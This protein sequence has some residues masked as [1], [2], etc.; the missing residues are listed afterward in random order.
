MD[1]VIL[2]YLESKDAT[3]EFEVRYS[4]RI[5]RL[6]YNSIV[7][8][9]SGTGFKIESDQKLLRIS[10]ADCR[11]QIAGLLNIKAYC[12]NDRLVDATFQK[13]VVKA[14]FINAY[15]M[16]AAL[17]TEVVL[18]A[19]EEEQLRDEW[20]VLDKTFRFMHRVTLA[21][22][23]YP[24]FKVDCSVVKSSSRHFKRFSL[25]DVFSRP[26]TCEVEIEALRREDFEVFKRQLNKISTLVLGG[27]QG[28]PFPVNSVEIK[29]VLTEYSKMTK[30]DLSVPLSRRF[31]GPNSVTLQ[32]AN[33]AAVATAS[34]EVAEEDEVV[35]DYNTHNIRRNYV[36]TDKADGLRKLLFVRGGRLY[37][38]TSKMEVEYAGSTVEDMDDT[39]L[40]GEFIEADKDGKPLRLFACFDVYF[41]K[42]VDVR[43]KL[44]QERKAVL[45]DVVA[46][47]LTRAVLK[48]HL[49]VKTFYSG[50]IFAACRDCLNTRY[51]YVT[52]GL[53]F[54]PTEYGVGMSDVVKAP[55]D[56][57][58]T[59]ALN[60]KWKPGPLNTIDFKVVAGREAA[61]H[62]TVSLLIVGTAQN[63]ENPYTVMLEQ[64]T[65]FPRAKDG[66]RAFLTDEDPTSHQ[67]NFETKGGNMQAANGDVIQSG[68][69]VECSYDGTRD[70]YW[71][72][73]PLRVRWDK[74]LPNGFVTAH[75]NWQT[76]INPITLE[77]V[78]GKQKVEDT[79]YYVGNRTEMQGIRFFHRHVKGCILK[80]VAKPGMKLVD[81]AVGEGGDLGRWRTE[82]LSFVLGM[83][84]SKENIHNREHGACVRYLEQTS[85]N[86]DLYALFV[87]GDATKDVVS[88]QAFSNETDKAVALGVLGKNPK[89]A[90]K[91]WNNVWLHHNT[92]FDLAS[93]MF[94]V[95][96]MFKSAATLTQFIKNVV[97]CTKVGGYLVGCAWDGELV[98]DKLKG[99]PPDGVFGMNKVTVVKRYCKEEFLKDDALGFAIDVSQSTFNQSTEYLVHYGFFEKLLARNGFRLVRLVPFK[100]EYAGFKGAMQEDEKELSFLNKYFIFEK[101]EHVKVVVTTAKFSVARIGSLT[102]K[103]D[104]SAPA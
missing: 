87:V 41:V 43:T 50:D 12:D 4:D 26:E 73:T 46:A 19:K 40:D 86:S 52:D 101:V 21:H 38:I 34:R 47:L 99:T 80:Q 89:E 63:W 65:H 78:T 29:N 91:Q 36:V 66:L 9:L 15:G 71:R 18:S 22:P 7:R 77:M 49:T 62:T 90:V 1:K 17:S 75:N 39:L 14:S 16:K 85:R 3:F 83:D 88:G 28:T 8:T 27:L 102:I 54:T 30:C 70:P 84:I 42:R 100:Q 103:T 5:S 24:A 92:L 58:T 45:D 96:Y 51:D 82:R 64:D 53:I 59:W 98:F 79:R 57:T 2:S 95:H 69:V 76:I 61:N 94:A 72:W 55:P 74:E 81:F 23:D 48:F 56:K 25:S 60:F 44:F 6:A 93:M 67:A 13:K 104:I 11:V 32:H 35:A 37:F 31:V 20:G 97:E 33:M 68:M 10:T